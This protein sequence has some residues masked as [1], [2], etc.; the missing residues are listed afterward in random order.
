M[1]HRSNIL[2]AENITANQCAVGTLSILHTYGMQLHPLIYL[3]QYFVPM[4]H[5][6]KQFYL[7]T[8][9][10]QLHLLIYLYQYFVPLAHYCKPLSFKN[11]YLTNFLALCSLS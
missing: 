5:Y 1:L 2:V 7:H 9:G 4:A 8:Y 10:M 3:Y 6:C 11:L